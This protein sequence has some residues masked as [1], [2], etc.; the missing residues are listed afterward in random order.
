MIGELILGIGLLLG[1]Q[2]VEVELAAVA[3]NRVELI[4]SFVD[5]LKIEEASRTILKPS[6]GIWR[7]GERDPIG[8][9]CN[10]AMCRRNRIAVHPNDEDSYDPTPM[11]AVKFLVGLLDL[12]END[13]LY[14]LGCGDGRVL[15]AAAYTSECRAVGIELSKERAVVAGRNVEANGLKG[16]VTI[17]RGDATKMKIAEWATVVFVYGDADFLKLLKPRFD[18]LRPGT[19]VVSYQ[20][21][22]LS[23]PKTEPEVR[24]EHKLYRY[25][26][27]MS[28]I[29]SM[30]VKPMKQTTSACSSCGT[31]RTCR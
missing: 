6:D 9:Y 3:A 27:P 5:C 11:E 8:T 17:H 4:E 30:V 25:E 15:I 22:V 18:E 28:E 23:F 31:C 26:V 13:V 7:R 21:P 19:I 12:D 14:D 24:G 29:A 20:H 16:R 1:A 2:V 10:C